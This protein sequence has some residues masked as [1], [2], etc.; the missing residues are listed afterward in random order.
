MYIMILLVSIHGKSMQPMPT[1]AGS[2]S[3]V[4]EDTL[5]DPS[6]VRA[7]VR[8]AATSATCMPPRFLQNSCKAVNISMISMRHTLSIWVQLV[9]VLEAYLCRAGRYHLQQDSVSN[10]RRLII[11]GAEVPTND[12]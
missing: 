6:H 5:V 8:S 2:F 10:R 9:L 11:G 7:G 12:T 1:T 3:R 4:S